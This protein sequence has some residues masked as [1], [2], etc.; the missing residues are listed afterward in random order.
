MK[1]LRNLLIDCR[2]ELRK[3]VRD[4]HKT[5]LC[6]RLDA[7]MSQLGNAAKADAPKPMTTGTTTDKTEKTPPPN[8]VALAWQTVAR[9][10]KFS[11][12]ALY[13][14]LQK[15][16]MQRL[17]T[18]S[19]VDPATEINELGKTISELK[20][21]KAREEKFIKAL[22]SERDTL[23]G[24]L[25]MAVPELS[26]GKDRVA[27]A[28][29]RI[30]WL[31]NAKAA[32]AAKPAKSPRTT[33]KQEA[34]PAVPAPESED[35]GPAPTDTV[36]MAVAAGARNF[37]DAHREWCVG[38]AMVLSGFEYTPVELI[39][40]GDAAIAEIIVKARKLTA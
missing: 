39:Q 26:D 8:Q 32:A 16:V 5:E 33:G 36:L 14:S 29:A 28:L 30:D 27:V 19:M 40:Q 18:K 15:K 21:Q 38:E 20:A 35:S 34:M 6:E 4:F 1:E 22:E 24:A 9:D 31:K 11:D 23:L 12:P 7:A 25:A 17:E 3:L 13:D 10:I 37:T 2:I